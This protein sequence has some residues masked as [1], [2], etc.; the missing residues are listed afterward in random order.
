VLNLDCAVKG[1]FGEAFMHGPHNP[2]GVM[3]AIEEVRV[4]ER[5]VLSASVDLLRYV[6][7]DGIVFNNADTPVVDNRDGAMQTSMRASMACLDIPDYSFSARNY[8]V[9]I[10][11]E[12][13]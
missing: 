13:W 11:I 9:R 10:T 6:G 7:E 4:T 3:D 2:E 8:Q 12:C 5:N 1:D